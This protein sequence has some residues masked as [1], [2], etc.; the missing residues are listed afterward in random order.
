MERAVAE[1]DLSRQ[2]SM[3]RDI[4]SMEKRFGVVERVG[5][6]RA[7]CQDLE[8]RGGGGRGGGRK[9]L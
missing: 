9:Q 8:V 7:R 3:S 1:S 4:A 6:L 2:P 5:A